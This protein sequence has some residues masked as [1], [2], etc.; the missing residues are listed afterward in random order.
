MAPIEASLQ[1]LKE[2]LAS[3]GRRR[4]DQNWLQAVKRGE[5]RA[6]PPLLTWMES[7]ELA[8]LIDGYALGSPGDACFEAEAAARTTGKWPTDPLQLWLALFF[9]HRQAAHTEL[10]APSEL[11]RLDSLCRALRSSLVGQVAG[12]V[13]PRSWTEVHFR[14]AFTSEGATP[15]PSPTAQVRHA[16]LVHALE[17]FWSAAPSTLVAESL[18]A[19]EL[20]LELDEVFCLDPNLLPSARIFRPDAWLAS[21]NAHIVCALRLG[22][23]FGIEDLLTHV[24]LLNETAGEGQSAALL[25]LNSSGDWPAVADFENLRRTAGSNFESAITETSLKCGVDSKRLNATAREVQIMAT[26]CAKYARILDNL[27]IDRTYH[28]VGSSSI[29]LLH[30]MSEGLRRLG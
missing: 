24:V 2:H 18:Y 11:P 28:D 21:H 27:T 26:S 23:Y 13:V 1:K 17:V 7:T 29:K 12:L 14:G 5:W 8:Y 6:I 15:D 20:K 10:P 22:R 25:L 3:N 30:G 19:L 16:K 9:T 4:A